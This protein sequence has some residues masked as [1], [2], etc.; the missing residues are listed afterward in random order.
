MWRTIF[1]HHR[2]AKTVLALP[3]FSTITVRSCASGKSICDMMQ[4]VAIET[5]LSTA[6]CF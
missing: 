3:K 6:V 2:S 5:T 4:D 1:L